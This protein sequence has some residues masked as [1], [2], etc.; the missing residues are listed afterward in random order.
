[1]EV[2]TAADFADDPRPLFELDAEVLRDEPGDVDH[3]FTDYE[4]WRRETWQHPLLSHALS[5]VAL[6]GGR[7][8]AFTMAHTDGKAYGTVMTGTRRAYRGRG[9]ARLVKNTS[10]HRAR[11]AGITEA[12]TGNDTGNG[13]ML[14]VNTWL[15]YEVCATEVR[16]VRELS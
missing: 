2:R 6:V 9:L 14:A 4:A 13:P 7:P 16:C 15:G 3:E 12:C 8:A 10:L 5:A 11:A 1:V